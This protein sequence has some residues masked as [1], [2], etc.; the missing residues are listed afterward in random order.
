MKKTYQS[1]LVIVNVANIISNI[2]WWYFLRTTGLLILYRPPEINLLISILLSIFTIGILTKAKTID[3]GEES[4]IELLDS[5]VVV[6]EK[7]DKGVLLIATLLT[8]SACLYVYT[9][10]MF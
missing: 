9:M 1:I 4:N 7:T 3:N 2:R 8:L 5:P 10:A 6:A